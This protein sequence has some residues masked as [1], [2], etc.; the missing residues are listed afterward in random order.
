MLLASALSL[1]AADSDSDAH[2]PSI[3]PQ[4][5][6]QEAVQNAA[7][8]GG[9]TVDTYVFPPRVVAA[10]DAAGTFGATVS[11]TAVA[12]AAVGASAV[13][14][15]AVVSCD[16]AAAIVG[17]DGDIVVVVVVDIVVVVV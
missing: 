15:I 16:V 12:G 6:L 7:E 8:I 14:V 3:R 4:G 5:L 1:L 9:C 2:A 11:G 17:G 13:A 10:G